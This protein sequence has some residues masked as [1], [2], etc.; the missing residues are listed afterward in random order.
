LNSKKNCLCGIFILVFV[1]TLIASVPTDTVPWPSWLGKDVT[2]GIGLNMHLTGPLHPANTARYLRYMDKAKVLGIKIIR[3]PMDPAVD[4]TTGELQ[5]FVDEA[6]RRGMRVML[7]CAKTFGADNHAPATQAEREAFRDLC[8]AM[9]TGFQGKGI[10]YEMW[11]EPNTD[12]FW[13]PLAIANNYMAAMSMAIAAMKAVDPNCIVI[14]PNSAGITDATAF[15]ETCFQQGML[16]YIDVV[17]AHPYFTPGE[18]PEINFTASRYPT[19]RTLVDSYSTPRTISIGSSELGVCQSWAGYGTLVRT[20]AQQARDITRS[21][22]VDM[23][24]RHPVRIIYTFNDWVD[25]GNPNFEGYGLFDSNMYA[26]D[27]PHPKLSYYSV[28]TLLQRLSG[29]QFLKMVEPS[30]YNANYY[31]ALFNGQNKA[32]IAA[33]IGGSFDPDS[34][35]VDFEVPSAPLEMVDEFGTLMTTPTMVNGR[36]TIGITDH[37]VYIRFAPIVV[38][39]D[40]GHPYPPGDITGDCRTDMN[41]LVIMAVDWLKGDYTIHGS[42]TPNDADLLSHYTFDTDYNDLGTLPRNGTVHGSAAIDTTP[43]AGPLGSTGYLDLNGGYVELPVYTGPGWITTGVTITAWVKQDVA[44]S[45]GYIFAQ[46]WFSP[47]ANG[48][49][50]IQTTPAGIYTQS[51][52]NVNAATGP[53]GAAGQWYHVAWVGRAISGMHE[54]WINGTKVAE[55]W[56]PW[57]AWPANVFKNMNDIVQI[58]AWGGGSVLMGGIDDLRVYNK[59]L[60]G[61]EIAYLAGSGTDVYVPLDSLANLSD[62]EPINSKKVNFKDLAV[63][64]EGWLDCTDPKPPCNYNP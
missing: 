13:P 38:C 63:L 21:V 42:G 59:A 19:L 57:A 61:Q 45:N 32:V 12:A 29:T 8:V 47:A 25:E 15:I 11:N 46:N 3:V 36:I 6:G 35:T 34:R 28:K 16:N 41:D 49:I 22:L 62:N 17:S 24:L 52:V 40:I 50:Q 44:G 31:V 55:T 4:F 1:G 56:M 26:A 64:A 58:G 60:S 53:Y 14:A 33:W 20:Q 18:S 5:W 37:P 2:A 30:P 10:I 23:V 43:G 51:L 54:V 9:V 7:L 39:G 48:T 27:G